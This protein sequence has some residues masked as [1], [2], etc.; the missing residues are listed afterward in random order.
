MNS[1]NLRNPKVHYRIHKSPPL[2]PLILARINP[3]DS[4]PSILNVYFNII[5]ESMY[6]F[7]TWSLSFIFLHQNPV[8]TSPHAPQNS[9]T[10]ILSPFITLIIFCD[11]HKSWSSSL[12]IFLQF[13]VTWSLLDPSILPSTLIS[14]PLG[15]C[16]SLIVREPSLKTPQNNRQNLAFNSLHFILCV[17]LMTKTRTKIVDGIAG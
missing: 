17:F 4:V 14:N 5:H 15:L 16:Y 10:F 6:M 12:S 2:V 9:A 11:N 1:L 7:P 3:V 8:A 13:P